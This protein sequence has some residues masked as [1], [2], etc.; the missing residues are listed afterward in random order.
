M[1]AYGKIAGQARNDGLKTDCKRAE[2][3][4]FDAIINSRCFYAL[5]P[6]CCT[7]FSRHAELVSASVV[8]T[9]PEI[10]SG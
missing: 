7:L 8:K 1:T 4:V 9:D 3:F 5:V 2:R 6:L 10:N